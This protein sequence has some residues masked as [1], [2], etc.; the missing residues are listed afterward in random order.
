MQLPVKIAPDPMSCVVLGL[1]RALAEIDL[2]R[3][4][5]GPV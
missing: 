1:G 3:R 5:S 2:L 4:V